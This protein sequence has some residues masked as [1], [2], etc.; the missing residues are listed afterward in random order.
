MADGI[1]GFYEATEEK[2]LDGRVVYMKRG[3]GSVCI[4]HFEGQWRVKKVSWMGTDKS[5][6]YV[7]GFCALEACT[8]REF[9]V[10]RVWKVW[11]GGKEFPDQPSVKILTGAEAQLQVSGCC[12]VAREHSPPKL[13]PSAPASSLVSYTTSQLPYPQHPPQTTITHLTRSRLALPSHVMPQ[14][15]TPISTLLAP[16]PQC[17][18]TPTVHAMTKA[19]ILTWNRLGNLMA[20]SIAFRQLR[21]S[22]RGFVLQ[23][24]QRCSDCHLTHPLNCLPRLPLCLIRTG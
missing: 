12:S 20:I 14:Q 4:E 11:D 6:A 21:L 8:S 7:F 18:W 10:S 19:Q 16:P 5:Y 23:W 3:D 2:G 24:K 15:P 22:T 17:L 13:N 9:S 1:N